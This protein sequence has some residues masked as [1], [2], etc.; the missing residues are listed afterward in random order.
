MLSTVLDGKRH[1]AVVPWT[2]FFFDSRACKQGPGGA[3]YCISFGLNERSLDLLVCRIH[4]NRNVTGSGGRAAFGGREAFGHCDLRRMKGFGLGSRS[5]LT[6]FITGKQQR[7]TTSTFAE[8][9]HAPGAR[10]RKPKWNDSW[11]YVGGTRYGPR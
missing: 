11:A 2:C 6:L 7:R 4:R 1:Q 9:R 3:T 8:K 10:N 5:T